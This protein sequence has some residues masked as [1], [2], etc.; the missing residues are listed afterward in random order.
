MGKKGARK[1][2]NNCAWSGVLITCGPYLGRYADPKD[3]PSTSSLR[4]SGPRKAIVESSLLRPAWPRG[5][6]RFQEEPEACGFLDGS[7]KAHKR[8]VHRHSGIID[9]QL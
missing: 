9:S 6:L 3:S 8:A 5:A 4:I 7:P 1:R 2:K